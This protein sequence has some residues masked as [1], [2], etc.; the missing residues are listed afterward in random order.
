MIDNVHPLP[1]G[2]IVPASEIHSGRGR[3]EVGHS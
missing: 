3:V 1:P 2:A